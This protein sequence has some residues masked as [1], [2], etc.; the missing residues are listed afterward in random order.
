[1]GR[2]EEQVKKPSSPIRCALYVR[3]STKDQECKTQVRQLTSCCR[4]RRWEVAQVFEDVGISGS[5]DSRP[6]LDDLMKKARQGEFD[7]VVV[8]RFDRFARSTQHL[9]QALQEFQS[10]GIDF[11]SF[12]EGVDTST[13]MGKLIYTFLAG[14]AEFERSLIRERVKAGIERAQEAGVHCGRPRVGFDVARAIKLSQEGL[15]VRRIAKQLGVSK[16]TI[17]RALRGV[18]KTPIPQL[19]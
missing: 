6:G 16:S 5:Q 9:L 7:A 3:V 8:Q 15:G 14:I 1:V 18:S 4:T 2:K 17:D 10:L 12:S 11:I 19:A 13:P